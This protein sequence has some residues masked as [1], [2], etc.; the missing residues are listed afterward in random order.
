MF[1]QGV[2]AGRGKA[3]Q[4]VVGISERSRTSVRNGN[5]VVDNVADLYRSHFIFIARIKGQRTHIY[6]VSG[7]RCSL[8]DENIGLILLPLAVKCHITAGHSVRTCNL[9]ALSAACI[10]V[11]AVKGPALR[12]IYRFQIGLLT[13]VESLGNR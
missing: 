3:V 13:F 8:G 6:A 9:V 5:S 1:K 2:A 12:C 10:R 7:V 4:G 11:P